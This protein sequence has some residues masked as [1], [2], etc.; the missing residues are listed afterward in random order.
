MKHSRE[1]FSIIAQLSFKYEE[2]EKYFVPL[3]FFIFAQF[4]PK[5]LFLTVSRFRPHDDDDTRKKNI[6]THTLLQ[7][8]NTHFTHLF[9]FISQNTSSSNE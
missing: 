3:F 5:F 6:Y 1:T 7:L 9:C 2:N 4:R 8:F